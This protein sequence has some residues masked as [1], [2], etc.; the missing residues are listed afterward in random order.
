MDAIAIDVDADLARQYMEK[1]R[2]A[3][4]DPRVARLSD[5]DLLRAFVE[6]RLREEFAFLSHKAE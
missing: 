3:F 6:D 4:Q 5:E 2:E 1:Y